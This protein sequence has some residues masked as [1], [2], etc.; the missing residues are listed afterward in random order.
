MKERGGEGR[1]V[2]GHKGK[3]REEKKIATRNYVAGEGKGGR[4]RNRR[5]WI[6]KGYKGMERKPRGR[7]G[8]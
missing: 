5:L 1:E 6:R 4:Q 8:S 3:E 2:R 7:K